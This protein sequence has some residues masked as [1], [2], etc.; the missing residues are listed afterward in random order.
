[1]RIERI[2]VTL[3]VVRAGTKSPAN[4]LLLDDCIKDL[5]EIQKEEEEQIAS[6]PLQEFRVTQR[7]KF[8]P[9][10]FAKGGITLSDTGKA[11]RFLVNT[12][13][14]QGKRLWVVDAFGKEK[15]MWVDMV[16]VM[17]ADD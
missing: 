10:V 1:M 17:T 4:K 9:E 8:N 15:P 16:T 6:L 11:L 7:I 5:K 14:D 2:I 12:I 13:D 3:G